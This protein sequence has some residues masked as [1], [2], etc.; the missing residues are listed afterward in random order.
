[1]E[2]RCH[3]RLSVFSKAG[4]RHGGKPQDVLLLDISRTG[5]RILLPEGHALELEELVAVKL[6]ILPALV[7]K[8]MRSEGRVAG[9]ALV[10]KLHPSVVQTVREYCRGGDMGD[11]AR[12]S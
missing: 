5:V 10:D 6:G 11:F 4:L 12:A 9:I 2:R 7:G 3:D 1:M 8:V